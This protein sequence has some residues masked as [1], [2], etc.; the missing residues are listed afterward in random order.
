M[1]IES[2]TRLAIVSSVVKRILPSS[3]GGRVVASVVVLALLPVVFAALRPSHPVT[4]RIEAADR[5]AIVDAVDASGTVKPI[6]SVEVGSQVSGRIVEIGTDYNGRVRADQVIARL[7]AATYEAAKKQY[8]AALAISEAKRVAADSSLAQAEVA[9]NDATRTA[10]RYRTLRQ[11]GSVSQG[12]LD[13]MELKLDQAGAAKQSALA[14]LKVAEATILQSRANLDRA[15]ADLRYTYIRSPV[16]GVVIARKVEVGQTV[17]ATLQAPV[18]F[19]IARDLSKMRVEASVGE[20]D[21]GR[22]KAGQAVTFTVDAFPDTTFHGTVTQVRM[23]ATTTQNVVSYTTVI[24]FANP[25][26]ILLPGMTANVSIEVAR[27]DTVLRVPVGATRYTPD[28]S[29]LPSELVDRPSRSTKSGGGPLAMPSPLPSGSKDERS[30]LLARAISAALGLDGET[31]Q[32]LRSGASAQVQV[33]SSRLDARLQALR[34]KLSVEQAKV[35]DGFAAPG[36]IGT[37]SLIWTADYRGRLSPKLVRLG[38]RDGD[39]VA[40]LAGDLDV[41]DE[42]IVGKVARATS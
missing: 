30:E 9:L 2:T 13:A 10:V 5:G 6:D 24:E 11:E 4:Y 41:G 40:V 7:D 17:A 3:F 27:T 36:A 21:I 12:D 37:L 1:P 32:L 31:A 39:H 18:L 25:D 16:D 19:E 29:E 14:D 42:V 34:P 22:V 38:A 28:R 26:L 23:S 8:A 15:E 33:D 20:A 35:L